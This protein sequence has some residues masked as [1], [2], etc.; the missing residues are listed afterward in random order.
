MSI[1][2]ISERFFSSAPGAFIGAGIL[3]LLIAA[4]RVKKE[5]SCTGYTIDI[6]SKGDQLFI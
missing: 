6:N 2:K 4:I 1:S 3:V 5:K